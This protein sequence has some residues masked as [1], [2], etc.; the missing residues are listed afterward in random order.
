MVAYRDLADPECNYCGGEGEHESRC[1][2]ADTLVYLRC[3]CIAHDLSVEALRD[4]VLRDVADTLRTADHRC[5]SRAVDGLRR[6]ALTPDAFAD[7]LADAGPLRYKRG[8][9]GDV[10]RVLELI[11][12]DDVTGAAKVLAKAI[13]ESVSRWVVTTSDELARRAA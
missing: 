12:R 9:E 13:G 8:A 3:H 10:E 2:P 4:M 7:L 11:R 6:G 5:M 1:A